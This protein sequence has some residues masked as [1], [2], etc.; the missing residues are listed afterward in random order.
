MSRYHVPRTWVHAGENLLVLHEELGGDPSK[1]SVLTRTG[2]EVC[3]HVFEDDSI[4]VDL[5]KSNVDSTSRTPEVRLTCDQG[6][7]ITS[8]RFASFGNPKGDCG[9]FTQG[10]CHTDV[11]SIVQQVLEL[12]F[13]LFVYCCDTL[14]KS[15]I[16]LSIEEIWVI[17]NS[18]TQIPLGSFSLQE[19][20]LKPSSLLYIKY[21]TVLLIR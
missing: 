6:W 16:V 15:Y 13:I 10:S 18:P 7:K 9:S 8:I 11:L 1:I 3:G 4:P 14:V 20:K 12:S 21:L 5:W 2:Q 19:L 17:R